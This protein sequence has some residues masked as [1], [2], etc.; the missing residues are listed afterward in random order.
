MPEPVQRLLALVEC[1]IL[2]RQLTLERIEQQRDA[3]L[4]SFHAQTPIEATALLQWLQATGLDFRF[5]SEHVIRLPLAGN[6]PQ[7]RL[8]LLKKHL[9]QLRSSVS[10]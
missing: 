5:Q 3:V 7:A 1:K 6:T 4:L 2:A 8:A 9:Q 10:L